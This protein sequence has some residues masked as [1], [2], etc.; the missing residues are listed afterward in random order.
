M[1][2]SRPPGFRESFMRIRIFLTLLLLVSAL[3]P[4]CPGRAEKCWVCH[5]EI[6][7]QVRA[8]LTLASGRSVVACCPRCALHYEEEPGNRVKEIRVT[9]YATLRPLELRR[10][11]L[12]E[13]SDETPCVHDHPPM[14]DDS[15]TPMQVCY[16]RC[17]PSLIAF[18]SEE[19]ARAFMQDHGGTLHPP[20]TLPLPLPSR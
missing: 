3:L 12:V 11:F 2:A 19:S 1:M 13:G 5:R 14:M 20:G 10:S 6:H 7:S 15:R 18:A 8:V 9:D 4:G 16:D 17:M